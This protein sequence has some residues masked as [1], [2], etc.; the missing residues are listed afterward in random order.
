MTYPSIYIL[1]IMYN[2]SLTAVF[3]ILRF[4]LTS[5]LTRA[6][7]DA[8]D[9]WSLISTSVTCTIQYL[10]LN[11]TCTYNT[12][13]FIRILRWYERERESERKREDLC[14]LNEWLLEVQ[15]QCAPLQRVEICIR[16]I[17]V[18]SRIPRMMSRLKDVNLWDCVHLEGCPL[19]AVP[20]KCKHK[21]AIQ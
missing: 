9:P 7:P 17:A 15:R 20:I 6:Y 4:R 1:C 18:S 19:A 5:L 21:H 13:D 14:R 11:V 2:S 8:L 16:L 10:Y 12:H 3:G